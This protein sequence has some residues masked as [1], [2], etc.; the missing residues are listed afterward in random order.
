MT[1]AT[2]RKTR[3]VPEAKT[4]IAAI[5]KR[6]ADLQDEVRAAADRDAQLLAALE[7]VRGR[8]REGSAKRTDVRIAERA[9]EEHRRETAHLDDA[10]K[11][12]RAELADLESFVAGEESDQARRDQE[13]AAAPLRAEAEALVPEFIRTLQGVGDT[14]I[15]RKRLAARLREEFPL[16]SPVQAIPM[17][18]LVRRT[19]GKDAG[20]LSFRTVETYIR[21]VLAGFE[22]EGDRNLD[23]RFHITAR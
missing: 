22:P 3:T 21:F 7:D 10:V 14:L 9:L 18:E 19:A 1:T 13:A 8:H 23:E 16:A 11:S 4:R 12:L 17:P 15:R 20:G 5:E 2:A 6:A